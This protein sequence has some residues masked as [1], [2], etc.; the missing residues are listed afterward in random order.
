MKPSEEP[1]LS[2]LELVAVVTLISVAATLS[3]CSDSSASSYKKHDFFAALGAHSEYY[4][5]P[6]VCYGGD[7][8]FLVR[9]GY[10]PSE[11]TKAEI[12]HIS[13]PLIREKG[14]GTNAIFYGVH[15]VW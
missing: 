3:T 7:S 15:I 14:A 2:T 10:K 6:E 9:Y 4:D 13:N 1:N 8:L 12:L 5:C 11:Y